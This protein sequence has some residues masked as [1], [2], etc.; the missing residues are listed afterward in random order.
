M[1]VRGHF[2]E[3]VLFMLQGIAGE[4]HSAIYSISLLL[5]LKS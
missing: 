5:L 3:I 2:F 1:N 4:F